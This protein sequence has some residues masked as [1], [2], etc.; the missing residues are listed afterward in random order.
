M[1]IMYIITNKDDKTD[2]EEANPHAGYNG[3]ILQNKCEGFVRQKSVK[4]IV[5]M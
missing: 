4:R 2:Y 3:H 1:Y 5:N